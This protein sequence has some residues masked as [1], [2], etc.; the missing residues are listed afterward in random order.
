MTKKKQEYRRNKQIE[1]KLEK[2]KEV[3]QQKG[4]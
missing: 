1:Y 3:A 4:K 2:I